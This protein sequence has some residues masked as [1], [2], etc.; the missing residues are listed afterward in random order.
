MN[1]RVE[2]FKWLSYLYAELTV[3]RFKVQKDTYCTRR[4]YQHT[5]INRLYA[6]IMI[7]SL[8]FII[9]LNDSAKVSTLFT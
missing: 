5:D 7:Y 3:Q 4:I 6:S 9:N 1:N 2:S 8:Y